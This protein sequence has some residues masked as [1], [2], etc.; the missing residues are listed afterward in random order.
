[1]TIPGFQWRFG[2]KIHVGLAIG[3][4]MSLLISPPPTAAQSADSHAQVIAQ[5]TASL[6]YGEYT[7]WVGWRPE[8]FEGEGVSPYRDTGFL[9]GDTGTTT[10]LTDG[11]LGQQL[12]WLDPGEGLFVQQ[13]SFQERSAATNDASY[14]TL[15][16]LPT[17]RVN[18]RGTAIGAPI[19]P[20]AS[21]QELTL[22]RDVLAP[23]ETGVLPGGSQPVLILPTA[24]AVQVS[25]FSGEVLTLNPG[26]A[27]TIA[28]AAAISA[29]SA[30]PATFVAAY[31]E[32]RTAPGPA[33]GAADLGVW[34]LVCPPGV[35][36]Q[37][38][39]S[40]R[41]CQYV[42]PLTSGLGLTITSPA[43]SGPLTL[44]NSGPGDAGARVWS[45][46][47]FST[48]TLTATLPRGAVGYAVRPATSGFQINLLPVGS[49]YSFTIDGTLFDPRSDYWRANFEVFLLY[50]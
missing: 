19:L 24:G 45:A 3:F 11:A 15:D 6:P 32:A 30:G 35:T 9:L 8:P 47:P 36:A 1:M 13:D 27:G 4:L 21:I 25:L 31:V 43:L 48:Y 18:A 40:G 41:G 17:G 7:W 33:T 29:I 50:P 49:G 42:D 20:D 39:M 44:G 10:V 12:V 37:P 16:L 22:Y 2:G 23:G 5:G 14:Y 26:E 46:I 34:V 38:D 28:G